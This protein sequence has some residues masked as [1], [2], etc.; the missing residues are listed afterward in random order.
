MTRG[1]LRTALKASSIHLGGTGQ[2]WTTPIDRDVIYRSDWEP[3]TTA[4]GR[5]VTPENAMSFVPFFAGVRLIAESVGRT[6]LVLYRRKDNDDRERATDKKLYGLLHDE[7]NP[8]MSAMVWKEA[9]QGHL[10]TRGNCYSEQARD[11]LGRVAELWPLRPDRIQVLRDTETR[12]KFFR[13]R[14]ETLGDVVD[15]T[16]DQVFHIPGFGF[17]GYVGYSIVTLFRQAIALGLAAEEFGARFFKSGAQPAAVVTVPAGWSDDKFNEY[18]AKLNARHSGLTN[19]QRIAVIEEGVSWD[20][21]GMN[22]DDAQF[23]ETRKFQ[24]GE[25]AT[26]LALPPHMIGDLERATFTNIEEQGLNLVAYS[27]GSWFDRWS[28]ETNRQLVRP[29][30]G[31]AMY[32]EHMP[33]ALLKGRSLDQMKVFQMLWQIGGINADTIARKLN[34]PAPTDGSG[35][36]YYRPVNYS[37][38]LDPTAAESDQSDAGDSSAR[39]GA[40]SLPT[41]GQLERVG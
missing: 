34:L 31:N 16:S 13:Y 29:A 41:D 18:S 28:Q 9:M 21:V 15:L 33:E 30:Y 27:F 2:G 23:L 5:S 11:D 12:K 40:G 10:V 20:T 6:P 36:G 17:D 7:P 37:L 35:A 26:M 8:E 39:N 4:V 32:A 14:I 38:A 1:I 25:T 22:L 24:R 19:A 3:Q